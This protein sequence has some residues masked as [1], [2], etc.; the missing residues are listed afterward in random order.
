L[1]MPLAAC[2]LIVAVLVALAWPLVVDELESFS[3]ET[4]NEVVSI[5]GVEYAYSGTKHRTLLYLVY[6]EALQDAGWLGHGKWGFKTEHQLYIDPDLRRTFRSIDNHYVLM[7]LNWGIIGCCTFLV[8]GIAGVSNAFRLAWTSDEN[9]Q[10][11]LG[12]LGGS[13]A[14]VLLMLLTVWFSSGFGFVW[15]SSLGMIASCRDVMMRRL[16]SPTPY[17]WSADNQV[18]RS[19]SDPSMIRLGATGLPRVSII[20]EPAFLRVS[21]E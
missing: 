10:V 8:I 15:L 6:R 7:T 18:P 20:H 2:G 21:D 4:S 1:R 9:Y 13:L 5:D 19:S 14:A 11:L 12:G 17:S 3:G 16:A